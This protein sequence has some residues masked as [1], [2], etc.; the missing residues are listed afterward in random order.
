MEALFPNLV[1]VFHHD[2]LAAGRWELAIRRGDYDRHVPN[3]LKSASHEFS[4]V[5]DYGGGLFRE[6]KKLHIRVLHPLDLRNA[7]RVSTQRTA[8]LAFEEVEIQLGS[9]TLPFGGN[10]LSAISKE[11]PNFCELATRFSAMASC[12]TSNLLLKGQA[13]NEA[14]VEELLSQVSSISLAIT[15]SSC[16]IWDAD[17]NIHH[18]LVCPSGVLRGRRRF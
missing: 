12:G 10:E 7:D 18:Q 13:L 8:S 14:K 5:L 17:S 16:L 11:V 15:E 2:T 4:K 3:I 9:N 1:A 6:Y